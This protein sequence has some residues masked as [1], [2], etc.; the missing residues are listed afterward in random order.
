MHRYN[1]GL[2]TQIQAAD[3]AAK[4]DYTMCTG[5]INKI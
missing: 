2:P 1:P 5:K 4:Y 3:I